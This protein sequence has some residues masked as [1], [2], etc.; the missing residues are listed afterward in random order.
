MKVLIAIWIVAGLVVVG[1]TVYM[2][3][4]IDGM[5]KAVPEGHTMVLKPVSAL[6]VT[7]S[8]ASLDLQP[9]GLRYEDETTEA[10]VLQPAEIDNHLQPMK[11][12]WFIQ[13]TEWR[14]GTTYNPQLSEDVTMHS[15]VVTQ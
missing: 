12:S 6:E 13:G 2:S 1:G 4:A 14:F 8:N 15:V 9:A 3:N 5:I 10:Q 11:H 7:S